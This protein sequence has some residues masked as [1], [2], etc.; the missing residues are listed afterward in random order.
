MSSPKEPQKRQ[1]PGK[2]V[3]PAAPAHV[4]L[5]LSE[6]L[7]MFYFQRLILCLPTAT[8]DGGLHD[9]QTGDSGV[10]EEVQRQEETEGVKSHLGIRKDI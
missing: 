3:F 10:P 8:L 7:L 6:L 2:R 4:N 9:A 1:I 5:S